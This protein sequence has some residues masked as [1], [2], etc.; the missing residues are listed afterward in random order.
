[1]QLTA[2]PKRTSGLV[3]QP[4]ISTVGSNRM[5]HT[6]DLSH[7]SKNKHFPRSGMISIPNTL[8]TKTKNMHKSLNSVSLSHFKL[9]NLFLFFSTTTHLP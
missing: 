6:R 2:D 1:M 5:L 4:A 9:P 8:D 7:N 3:I